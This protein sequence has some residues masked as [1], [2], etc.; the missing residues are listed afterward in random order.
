MVA[1]GS[2]TVVALGMDHN[3]G[4]GCGT[5]EVFLT[6]LTTSALTIPASGG[7]HLRLR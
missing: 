5:V 3:T 1:Y 6:S 2:V 7:N 4:K